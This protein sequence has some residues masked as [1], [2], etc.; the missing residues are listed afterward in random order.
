LSY[1]IMGVIFV[2][3]YIYRRFYIAKNIVGDV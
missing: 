1:L 3:E 2:G